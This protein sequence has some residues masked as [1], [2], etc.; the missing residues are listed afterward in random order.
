LSARVAQQLEDAIVSGTFKPGDSLPTERELGQMFGVSRTVVREAV[1]SLTAKGMLAGTG[2]G[3]KIMGVESKMVADSLSLYLRGRGGV[4]YY[5]VHEIRT[6]LERRIARLAATRGTDEQIEEL[7]VE[8]GRMRL[9]SDPETASFEDVAFHRLLAA[10]TGNPLFPVLLDSIGEILLEVRRATLKQPGRP[11]QAIE[12]HEA[13]L[14]QIVARDGE[15]A[16]RAM[17]EHL[18]DSYRIWEAAGLTDSKRTA[19]RRRSSKEHPEE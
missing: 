7:A 3:T 6:L 2:R 14:A 4:D 13:I 19:G 18:A 16:E 10:M 17:K 9:A 12:Q 15:G 8:L 5:S 1:K 11:A